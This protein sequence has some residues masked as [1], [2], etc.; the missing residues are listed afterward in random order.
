VP[1]GGC[2]RPRAGAPGSPSAGIR[3]GEPAPAA[4]TGQAPLTSPPAWP[5]PA[6]P[7]NS[8]SRPCCPAVMLSA[9]GGWPGRTWTSARPA[10]PG[11]G[12]APRRRRWDESGMGG[13]PGSSPPA[14]AT[15][16]AGADHPCPG[17]SS[18]ASLSRKL[19]AVTVLTARLLP[20]PRHGVRDLGQIPGDHLGA[21][22]PKLLRAMV[23][24]S[25]R[26]HAPGRLDRAAARPPS[27]PPG[28][29]RRPRR[30]SPAQ[31][32]LTRALLSVRGVSPNGTILRRS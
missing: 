5:G 22:L 14:P 11:G 20:A 25:V 2:G 23:F 26:R 8:R 12:P 18:G 10:A 9:G 3:G 19:D 24:G 7:G 16:S 13:R 32:P 1:R 30:R 29:A 6:G 17:P 31:S 4:T 15:H 21:G 28:R 27:G